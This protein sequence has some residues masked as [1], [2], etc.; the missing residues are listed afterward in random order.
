MIWEKIS[1][2][3]SCVVLLVVSIELHLIVAIKGVIWVV[4]SVSVSSIGVTIEVNDIISRIIFFLKLL[5]ISMVSI[6]DFVRVSSKVSNV[7]I[8]STLNLGFSLEKSDL[9]SSISASTEAKVFDNGVLSVSSV[10]DLLI[11]SGVSVAH[12]VAWL[13]F[14]LDFRSSIEH[15][16]QLRGRHHVNLGLEH[17]GVSSDISASTETEVLYDCVF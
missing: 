14:G 16:V 15:A 12:I 5:I 11:I 7:S 1:D 3:V 13:V 10:I 2:R 6:W 4:W 17:S 9:A 8:S